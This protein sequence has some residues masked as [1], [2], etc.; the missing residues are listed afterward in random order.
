MGE[1]ISFQE[2]KNRARRE[3]IRLRAY[4]VPSEAP[5]HAEVARTL[6]HNI[7]AV[8]CLL[9]AGA[10]LGVLGMGLWR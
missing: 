5:I 1:V 3:R 9:V 7:E 6:S 8:V 2:A 10:V 4:T